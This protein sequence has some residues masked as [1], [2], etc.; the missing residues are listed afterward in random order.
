MPGT[1]THAR[2]VVFRGTERAF[3]LREFRVP[4]PEPGTVLLRMEL[5]GIC[6]TDVHYYQEGLRAPTILGHENTGIIAALGEGVETDSLGR[7]VRV[8]DRVVVQPGARGGAYGLRPLPEQ[9]PRLTGG[10]AEYLY[11]NLPDTRF[12][13]TDLPAEIAVL[14][15]P[16]TVA[17]HAVERSRIWLGDTVVIQG[18]GAIGLMCLIAARLSGASKTIVIGGPAGRL[19]FAQRLGADRVIN[20]YEERD[21]AARRERVL[22]ETPGRSGADVVMECAGVPSAIVEGIEM[23]RRGGMF[24]ELG[25]FVDVGDMTLNPNRHMVWKDLNLVAPLGSRTEHFVRGLPIMEKHPELFAGM[26][27]H[28]LPLT[29][30]QEAF[31]ALSG[32]YRLDGRDAIKIAIEPWQDRS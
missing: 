8:G 31:E 32:R 10:Q 13:K 27:S 7:P 16:F 17:I 15:E 21:P 24:C 23:L 20:I 25:H 5:C 19:E 9:D 28:R 22:A 1:D 3:D 29:R 12:F 2:A 26:V 30:V 6:G 4:E 18:S 11:L 14:L